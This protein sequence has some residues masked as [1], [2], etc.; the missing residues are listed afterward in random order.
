MSGASNRGNYYYFLMENAKTPSCRKGRFV[1]EACHPLT[2]ELRR[3]EKLAQASGSADGCNG[4]CV[5]NQI[6]EVGVTNP[7]S[8]SWLG[9]GHKSLSCPCERSKHS[10]MLA[11]HVSSPQVTEKGEIN[12]AGSFCLL[13]RGAFLQ[14]PGSC[15]GWP[16][17]YM[18]VAYVY[19]S[20]NWGP[21]QF[22]GFSFVCLTN[23]V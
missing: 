19:G 4:V 1:S 5:V 7:G 2:T 9:G 18:C 22:S 8:V 13:V 16:F 14:A 12:K 6:L 20:L 3:W 11:E 15:L 10:H 21:P 17:A 23:Q